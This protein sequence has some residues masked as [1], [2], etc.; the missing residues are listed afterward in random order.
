MSFPEAVTSAFQN[1]VN[2]SG[3]ARRSEYWY[4]TIFVG[5]ISGVLSAAAK[6]G[7]N[8][9]ATLGTIFALATFL[10]GLSVSWRRLHDIGKSGW[11]NLIALVPLIGWIFII[12]WGCKDSEP[13]ANK[14]GPCPK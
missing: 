14:Y 13:N 12:Y 7:V 11:W 8:I 10:P 1:Y 4:F 3:R 2:F 5:I 9:A 6:N